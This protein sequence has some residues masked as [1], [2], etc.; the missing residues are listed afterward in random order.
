MT[1]DTDKTTCPG[2]F[3][4]GLPVIAYANTDNPADAHRIIGQARQ[5][6]DRTGPRC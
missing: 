5:R 6:W 2:V 3:D 1:V 4:A